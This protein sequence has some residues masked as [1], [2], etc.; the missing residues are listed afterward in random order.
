N[1]PVV[2]EST[3]RRV[4]YNISLPGTAHRP[5]VAFHSDYDT[6]D[7]V[8]PQ[9]PQLPVDVAWVPTIQVDRQALERQLHTGTAQQ[10]IAAWRDLVATSYSNSCPS[11]PKRPLANPWG[12]L[13]HAYGVP[14]GSFF[15]PPVT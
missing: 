7:F 10:R 3:S 1:A 6:P 13:T 14:P 12:S 8:I 15:P 2:A 5:Q 9:L 11:V 4:G